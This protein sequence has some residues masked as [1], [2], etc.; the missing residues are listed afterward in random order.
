[1]GVGSISMMMKSTEGMVRD[2]QEAGRERSFVLPIVP[3]WMLPPY[4]NEKWK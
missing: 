3:S 2:E 4:G 1:M